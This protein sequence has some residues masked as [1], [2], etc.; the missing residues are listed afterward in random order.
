LLVMATQSAMA[1]LLTRYAGT[2]GGSGGDSKSRAK[3]DLDKYLFFY[4]RY[5]N[6]EQAAKFAFKHRQE[7]QR[8][9][10][11]LA[12]WTGAG[13]DV[14]ASLKQFP[15][16][17]RMQELQEAGGLAYSDVTFLNDA[18]EALLE[19]RSIFYRSD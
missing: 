8:V 14:I 16:L 11:I 13:V 6:H 18:T 1:D 3:A 10:S 7:A 19:V 4:Q 9:S 5:A 12:H 15:N 17:Q 2:A